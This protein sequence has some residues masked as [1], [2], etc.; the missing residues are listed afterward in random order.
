[1]RRSL[2]SEIGARFLLSLSLLVL[3]LTTTRPK[4]S[5]PEQHQQQHKKKKVIIV[6]AGSAGMACADQLSLPE[7][8]DLFDVTLVDVSLPRFPSLS[9][10]RR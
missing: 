2:R 9:C 1:M 5:M 3:S 10:P 7:N 4:E 6:G 8:R